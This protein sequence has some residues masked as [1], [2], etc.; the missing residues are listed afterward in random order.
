MYLSDDY[1]DIIDIF[2]EH[3]VKY[4]VV[5]AYAM[6]T[7]GYS[8]STYDI[9]LWVDKE[10]SNIE[11]VILALNEF[12]VPFEISKEDLQKENS[13]IQI[14]VA[15]LR[16]DILTDIDGI[17]FKEA[18]KNRVIQNLDGLKVPILHIDDIIKNKAASNRTKDKIDILELKKLK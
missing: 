1:K 3:C 10:D 12:G 18:Y 15:P 2:N 8:R 9:D 16:I 7:F 6:A 14:G 5:G 4:L 13:V 11:K 17:K